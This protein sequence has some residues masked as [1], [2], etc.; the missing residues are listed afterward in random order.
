MI[1]SSA[2]MVAGSED[3]GPGIE[4]ENGKSILSADF[5]AN[6]I[7]SSGPINGTVH[8]KNGPKAGMGVS[9]ALIELMEPIK[10][11]TIAITYT[12]DTG[13]YLLDPVDFAS[14]MTIRASP[15]LNETGEWDMATGYLLSVSSPFNH[16]LGSNSSV[17]FLLNY[18]VLDPVE[19]HPIIRMLDSEGD[20]IQGARVEVEANGRHYNAITDAKGDVEFVQFVGREFPIGSSFTAR[21]DGYV[22]V[23]W[24]QGDEVPYL[25]S[26]GDESETLTVLIILLITISAVIGLILIRGFLSGR[27]SG[28][29]AVFIREP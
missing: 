16:S 2:G 20:P 18:Y 6:T 5:R 23:S 13:H 21:A 12:N 26:E 27:E 15:P 1:L 28:E 11:D 7:P 25:S 8:Y 14:D 9:G 22:T 29:G 17:S 19:D 10:G 24:K 3:S 4:A